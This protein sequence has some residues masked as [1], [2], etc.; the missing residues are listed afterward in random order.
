M[1]SIV[2]CKD[3]GDRSTRGV[4]PIGFIFGERDKVLCVQTDGMDEEEL[5]ELKTVKEEYLKEL[6]ELG[7][8]ADIRSFFVDGIEEVLE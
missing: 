1:T 2:Y 6:Y 7:F 5:N 4:I 8:G 3:N